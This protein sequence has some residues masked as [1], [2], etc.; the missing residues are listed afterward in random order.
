[1]NAANLSNDEIVVLQICTEG[2]RYLD[3][4]VEARPPLSAARLDAPVMRTALPP[5]HKL[6]GWTPDRA[7]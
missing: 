3:T 2:L 5:K 6:P 7:S 1:M 4:L